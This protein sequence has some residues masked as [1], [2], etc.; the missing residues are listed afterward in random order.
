MKIGSATSLALNG[1]Q[2]G[3]EGTRHNADK[4]AAADQFN[5]KH[6]PAAVE[7]LIGL[8]QNRLQVSASAT[9]L[10]VIDEMIGTLIDD[11]A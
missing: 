7:A 11:E 6:P 2:R 1:I 5:S 8:K 4:I 3:M 9:L 10:S